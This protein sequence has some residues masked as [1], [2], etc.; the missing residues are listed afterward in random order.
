MI[1]WLFVALPRHLAML[2]RHPIRTVVALASDSVQKQKQKKE[3]YLR[4]RIV[5]N[6]SLLYNILA[7]EFN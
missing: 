6:A 4:I 3:E 7:P 2:K 5:S 1:V